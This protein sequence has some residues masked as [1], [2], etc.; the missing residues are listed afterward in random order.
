MEKIKTF[1]DACRQLGINP[2]SLPDFSMIPE[3]HRKALLAHYKLIIIAQALN[4][5]WKPNWNDY[6]E[7]KY[8]PWFAIEADDKNHSG[9][10]LSF[11]DYG[12]WYAH[13]DVG[14]RLCFKSRELAKYAATQFN[15][16]YKDYMLLN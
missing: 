2:E 13:A 9:V 15:E 4:D 5:G 6:D 8:Y 14:S 3:N 7:Y 1:E 16:L 12:R 11:R 10:G